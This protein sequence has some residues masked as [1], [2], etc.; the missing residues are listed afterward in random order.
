M[1][2]KHLLDL[3]ICIK[4]L[5][6]HPLLWVLPQHVLPRVVVSER[7]RP[8]HDGRRRLTLGTRIYLPPELDAEVAL[9]VDEFSR[10]Q[11]TANRL[12][13]KEHVIGDNISTSARIWEAFG[14]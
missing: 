5:V 12:E 14:L 11:I 13:S 4:C 6:R 7:R 2:H 1:V 10:L 9:Q 8:Y 3:F